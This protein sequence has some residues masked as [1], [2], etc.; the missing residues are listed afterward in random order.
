[1]AHVVA[2]NSDRLHLL[3]PDSDTAFFR[4]PRHGHASPDE[5]EDYVHGQVRLVSPDPVLLARLPVH[6][7]P[8]LGHLWYL[9]TDCTAVGHAI[10]AVQ[11]TALY[12][13]P[14]PRPG[15]MPVSLLSAGPGL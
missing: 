2:S 7:Q 6:A 15:P 1:M 4:S 14:Q 10:R 13:S 8:R 11:G 9:N 3:G 12:S 5:H